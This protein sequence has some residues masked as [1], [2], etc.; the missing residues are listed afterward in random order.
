M[1]DTMMSEASTIPRKAA[2]ARATRTR[3]QTPVRYANRAERV[4]EMCAG[5]LGS[6]KPKRNLLS[7][8]R[9]H[10]VDC[11]ASR[12]SKAWEI[13]GVRMGL[14]SVGECVVK[15]GSRWSPS[16]LQEGSSPLSAGLGLR[17]RPGQK[18]CCTTRAGE[19]DDAAHESIGEDAVQPAAWSVCQNPAHVFPS[20][21][22]PRARTGRLRKQQRLHI[23]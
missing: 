10:V 20:T 22:P 2:S 14:G 19:P 6:F 7:N 13:S 11:S 12:L 1:S 15:V 5:S 16:R 9:C 17:K 23:I 3:T 4:K 21:C 8:N 18:P